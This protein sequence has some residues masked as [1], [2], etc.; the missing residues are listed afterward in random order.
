MK[1]K[2]KKALKRM[3]DPIRSKM[4][5][6]IIPPP[7]NS[8]IYKAAAF[9]ASNMIEGDY[10]EFGSASGSTFIS[11]FRAL[12]EAFHNAYTPSFWNTEQDCI[13]R[14][15]SW[16]KMRF[17]AFDSFQGL[18]KPTGVD[19]LS[20]DFVEG[21]FSHSQEDFK[22]NIARQGI[23]QNR[24]VIVPGW[25][26]DTLNANLVK[27]HNIKKA[28]IVHIDCDLYESAKQVLAFVTP[29]LVDGTVII[30]DD[31]Y[32][33]KGDPSLG[34]QRACS[35]WLKFNPDWTLTQYQKEGSW[36]NSFIANKKKSRDGS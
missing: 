32:C 26:K 17:F 11:A 12:E 31:W 5:R 25:F 4:G 1:T 10:L 35:E 33:Y 18:P 24:T 36:R 30:F 19:C 20:H 29:L 7:Q 14:S 28:S 9:V 21:K 3:I 16:R 23:L 15:K 8:I 22:K 6:F 13:E 27:K 2:V 34:E